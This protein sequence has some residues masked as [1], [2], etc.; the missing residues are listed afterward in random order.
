MRTL[1]LIALAA[2]AAA[3]SPARCQ[4]APIANAPAANAPVTVTPET[5]GADLLLAARKALNTTYYYNPA[6]GEF[7]PAEKLKHQRAMVAQN[8]PA[9]VLLRQALA[10]GIAAPPF[11]STLEDDPFLLLAPAREMAQQL[12]QE[13]DVRAADGDALG[14]VNT[15]FDALALGA[16][17]GRGPFVASLTGIALTRIAR[18]SLESHAPLLRAPQLRAVAA[19]WEKLDATRLS[20][21][22]VIGAYEQNE[23]KQ[24][25]PIVAD[26]EQLKVLGL[27]GNFKP[28]EKRQLQT[29]TP[30][31]FRANFHSVVQNALARAAW[32]YRSAAEAAP[33]QAGDPVSQ[34]SAQLFSQPLTR[35]NFTQ[36]AALNTLSLAALKLRATKLET[37]AYPDQ[38]DAGVDPFS[39]ALAPLVYRREGDK[40]LLYSVG[41]DG[42]DD[43][44]A[45]IST[46]ETDRETGAPKVTARLQPQSTGDIV[47]PVF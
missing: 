12:V 7:A 25:E 44:G 10:R 23:L 1:P 3:A 11:K 6:P 13:A 15:D 16:Q 24:L 41:P 2:T 33:I 34:W 22:Q 21:A 4:D 39:P 47:A 45:A 35:L 38:F 29:L 36:D 40:Y 17:I 14:A 5:S 26:P 43:G 46:V 30:A 9:L 27:S 8:A 20:Y 28:M 37:G 18:Q 42:K 31:E 32:P 19:R